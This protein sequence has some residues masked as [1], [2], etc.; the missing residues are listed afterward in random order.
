MF[1]P[2]KIVGTL[3][4]CEQDSDGMV[5]GE[6]PVGEIVIYAKR[7]HEVQDYIDE[8]WPTIEAQLGENELPSQ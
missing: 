7:F 8:L 5:I 2:F 3:V 4:A 1:S 6:V